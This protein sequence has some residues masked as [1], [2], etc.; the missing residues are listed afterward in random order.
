MRE[1]KLE[2]LVAVVT[3]GAT[4]IGRAVA[5][6]FIEHGAAV[7]VLDR[8]KS[9]ADGYV[10]EHCTYY[11]CNVTRDEEVSQAID[12]VAREHGSIDILVNSAGVLVRAPFTETPIAEQWKT[13]EVNLMGTMICCQAALP[14][15]ITSGRGRIIN[16]AS[17]LALSGRAG[18][19]SYCA[20]KAGVIGFTKALAREVA[21][22]Q[23]TANVVAPGPVETDMVAHLD[24]ERRRSLEIDLPLGR[25][26]TAAEVALTALF[27]ASSDEGNLYTGQTLSP[28]CGDVMP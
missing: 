4:G 25:F 26:G 1:G 27:L 12:N 18:L 23:V 22:R 15:L 7:S 6:L 20:S 9:P 10:T 28:N 5:Q 8:A 14:H 11:S 3:G 24:S 19:T 21:P 16:F 13:V 17:Q 2:G